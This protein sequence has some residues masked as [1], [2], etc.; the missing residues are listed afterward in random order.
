MSGRNINASTAAKR[1]SGD[2]A[3]ARE[4]SSNAGSRKNSLDE[5]RKKWG[6][7]G[8]HVLASDD[9]LLACSTHNVPHWRLF[10]ALHAVTA[11]A[12]PGT[13]EGKKL[14]SSLVSK[15]LGPRAKFYIQ[16]STGMVRSGMSIVY[17]T[18]T[19][20]SVRSIRG[21]RIAADMGLCLYSC[22][23]GKD[24]S[25]RCRK[26]LPLLLRH[27]RRKSIER[28]RDVFADMDGNGDG[29][30]APHPCPVPCGAPQASRDCRAPIFRHPFAPDGLASSRVIFCS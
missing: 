25:L 1:I 7:P 6:A 11:P 2:S 14:Q 5:D 3:G 15:N 19:A 22:W 10:P 27:I 23:K 30:S 24:V 20:S 21:S 17:Q 18:P 13:G 26:H 12:K 29:S 8:E 16:T 9:R 28:L 4:P